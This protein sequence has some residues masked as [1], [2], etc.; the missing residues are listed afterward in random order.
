MAKLTYKKLEMSTIN[1][2]V[3]DVLVVSELGMNFGSALSD[4]WGSNG[5][6][7]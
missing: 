3:Q 5:G 1:F 6:N 7:G 4:W 2:D